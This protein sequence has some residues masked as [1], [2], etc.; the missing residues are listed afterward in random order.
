MENDELVWACSSHGDVKNAHE[1]LF[2]KSEGKK[3]LGRP[4]HR[5]DDNIKTDPR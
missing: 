3:T 2:G 5:W 1:I 4:R